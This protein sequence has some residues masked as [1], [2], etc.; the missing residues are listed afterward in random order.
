MH[1]AVDVERLAEFSDGT[2]E[3]LRTLVRIFLEDITQMLGELRAAVTGG[4]AVEIRLL[5]H[6][7]AGSS[8]GNPLSGAIRLTIST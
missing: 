8:S 2:D 5:A 6:R 4:D 3:G 1:P 7:C